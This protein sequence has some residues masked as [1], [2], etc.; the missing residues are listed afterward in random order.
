[1]HSQG[2]QFE[3]DVY[4]FVKALDP[5]AGVFFNHKVPDK[6]TGSQ[7]QV[8]VWVN[9]K[10][11]GHIPISILV[12]CKDH[13]RKL[14]INHIESFAQEVQ[15]TRASTGIIYSSSGFTGPALEKARAK[16]LNCCRLFRNEPAD[17]PD[18]L[19]FWSYCCTPRMGLFLIEPDAKVLKQRNVVYWDDLLDIK[20]TPDTT[21]L[22]YIATQYLKYEELAAKPQK[23]ANPFPQ[24]WQLEFSF[25]PESK[26]SWL[27]K[28]KVC[29]LWRIY[30]GK[31]EAHLLKGSYC[32]SNNSFSGNMFSPAVDTKEPPGA[33]WEPIDGELKDLPDLRTVF[34]FCRPDAKASIRTHFAGKR[35]L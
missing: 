31:R 9:A 17:I 3:K 19:I 28:M 12:S 26:P 30:R 5:K 29:G 15:S 22:D 18:R 7:R 11:G 21:L 10:L 4:A 34:I 16:G 6:D 32:F 35:I 8:D 24:S 13:K 20:V 2:T 25:S 27:F 1:M 14:N 33:A 23:A